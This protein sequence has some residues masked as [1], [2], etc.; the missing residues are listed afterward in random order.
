MAKF[1]AVDIV[2]NGEDKTQKAIT[3]AKGG[4]GKLTKAVKG[5]GVE[6]AAVAAAVYGAVKIVKSL[7]DAYNRQEEANA[8]LNSALKATHR[9]TPQVEAS[10]RA[11]A[12]QMQATTKYGDEMIE[13]AQGIMATFTQ[14]S[15]DTFPSAMDAAADMSTMFGQDLQQSVIQLGTA[16][17]DPIAGVG[18]L[19]RI[20]IS[21]TDTQKVMI[22][23]FMA[24]ND[25]A[26][27][28][29]VILKE[30]HN[31]IGGVAKAMGETFAGQT[32]KLKNAV[33]D[34]KET[35]GGLVVNVMQ[36][37]IPVMLNIV[38]N[39]DD[40]IKAKKDLKKAYED[41]KKPMEDVTDAMRLEYLQS[42]VLVKQIQYEAAVREYMAGKRSG[43]AK[44]LRDAM[45]Q[46]RAEV[47]Q[48]RRIVGVWETYMNRVD[49][50]NKKIEEAKKKA[51][52]HEDA[53]KADKAAIDEVTNSTDEWSKTIVYHDQGLAD[54]IEMT[55]SARKGEEY[56]RS[57]IKKSTDA[58]NIQASALDGSRAAFIDATIAAETLKQ[59]QDEIKIS[60]DQ[61]TE[62]VQGGLTQAFIDFANATGDL[63]KKLGSLVKNAFGYILIA[64]GKQLLALAAELTIAMRFVQAAG[65]LAAGVAAIVAGNELMKAQQ[66]ATVKAQQGYGGGDN[67]PMMLE[68]GEMVMRK[69][70]VSQNRAT[71]DAMNSGEGAPMQVNVYLG[72]KLIYNEITKAI[73]N[74][75]IL[76]SSGAV[77]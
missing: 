46:Q 44:A 25:I 42:M 19:K 52:E 70:V 2:I 35:M 62:S 23:N 28:Q 32:A 55:D 29:G 26:S 43:Q 61:I 7:T 5:Y 53:V 74:K 37:M 54:Y 72:T 12:K 1:D 71:L 31:E 27:A 57:A 58:I 45:L 51:K 39:I 68:P 48:M 34:L 9:Y 20:G 47:D 63:E 60:S 67:V 65:A 24:Q 3:S 69:E 76:V 22:Q 50:S 49:E 64:I 17:N 14:I 4:I 77:V 10:M 40:W 66:G 41:I 15:N 11:Y 75:Q 38:T 30:L 59:V 6:I 33:S 8:K 16:L 21:F 56:L 73:R 13:S 36:P 18:R